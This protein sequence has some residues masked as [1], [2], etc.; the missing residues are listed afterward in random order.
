M[1]FFLGDDVGFII[2]CNSGIKFE[3]QTGGH[4]CNQ[5]EIEGAFIPVHF[6]KI[7]GNIDDLTHQSMSNNLCHH[8]YDGPHKGWCSDGIQ[9][10]D[11]EFVDTVLDYLDRKKI[12]V[13]REKL[14]ESHEAWVHVKIDGRDAIFTWP[15]SD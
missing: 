3:V 14:K 8:F 6:Y 12:S 15:N 2:P 5:Q 4:A 11:A 7:G 10:E 1:Q 13:N 9:K